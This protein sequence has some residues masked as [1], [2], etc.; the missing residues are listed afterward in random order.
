VCRGRSN[1]C[2]P[3]ALRIDKNLGNPVV[4]K[5]WGPY[6]CGSQRDTSFICQQ[7]PFS[8]AVAREQASLLRLVC[9]QLSFIVSLS[10]V[11]YI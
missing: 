3:L 7:A 4:K 10:F 2:N 1:A 5:V 8:G 9:I 6:A 11:C